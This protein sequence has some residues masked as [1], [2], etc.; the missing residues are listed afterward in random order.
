M[1][2]PPN[3]GMGG[4]KK[5][6]RGALERWP[7]GIVLHNTKTHGGGGVLPVP[8][9]LSGFVTNPYLPQF[10]HTPIRASDIVEFR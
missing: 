7:R 2:T 4:E 3:R 10:R 1:A 6:H 8:F 5:R 9:F